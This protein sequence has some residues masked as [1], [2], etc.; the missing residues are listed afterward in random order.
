M[1]TIP[2]SPEES[3]PPIQPAAAGQLQEPCSAFALVNL[4]TLRITKHSTKDE[5]SCAM[6]DYKRHLIRCIP[7]RW[8][9]GAKT[10][11]ALEVCE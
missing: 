8:H 3:G 4:S 11:V 10:W 2:R 1:N 9:E 7:L 5:V 6:S